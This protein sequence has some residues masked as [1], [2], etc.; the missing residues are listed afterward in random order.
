[1]PFTNINTESDEDS[2]IPPAARPTAAS[3]LTWVSVDVNVVLSTT[4]IAVSASSKS[5][6]LIADGKHCPSDLEA[7]LVV[8]F[9]NHAGHRDADEDHPYGHHRVETVAR[10][11]PVEAQRR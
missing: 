1:M 2:P 11:S 10:A 9:A 8:L 5:Q 7:D 4:Q 6:E 3:R